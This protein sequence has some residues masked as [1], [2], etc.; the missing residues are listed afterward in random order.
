MTSQA[1]RPVSLTRVMPRIQLVGSSHAMRRVHREALLAARLNASVLISGERGVGK[2]SIARFIH[3]HSDR[4]RLGFATIS[5]DGLPDQLFQSALFGHV[6]GSFAGA[7]RD[8][9]GVLESVAGGTVF[10]DE[11]GALSATMQARLL[12]FLESGKYQRFGENRV[13]ARLGAR[14]DRLDDR[15]SCRARGRRLVSG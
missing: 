12:W 4:S 2:T 7:Y 15:E 11:V 1:A 8:K 13:Q 14:A 5:C 3:E 6:T 9:P 10:L